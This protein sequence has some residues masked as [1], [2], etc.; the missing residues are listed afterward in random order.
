[1]ITVKNISDFINSIAPYNTKCEWDNCGIL[2]GDKD[3]K[4]NKIG[5]IQGDI[6]WCIIQLVV[7]CYKIKE[8]RNLL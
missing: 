3:K 8:R 6:G 7:L 4:V 1:M 2:I 5:Y